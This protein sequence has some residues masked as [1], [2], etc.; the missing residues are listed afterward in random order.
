MHHVSS[1]PQDN[2]IGVRNSIFI[3]KTTLFSF[4]LDFTN[5]Q[6]VFIEFYVLLS[7]VDMHIDARCK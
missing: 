4:F 1:L 2:I 6:I 7:D 5:E 3:N